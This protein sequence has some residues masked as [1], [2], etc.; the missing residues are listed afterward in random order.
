[1]VISK[2]LKTL[3]HTHIQCEY[4]VRA[5]AKLEAKIHDNIDGPGNS[6]NIKEE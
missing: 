4:S 2:I 1:M 3:Q 6:N 5:V